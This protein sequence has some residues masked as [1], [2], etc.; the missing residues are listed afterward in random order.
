[1]KIITHPLM[2][3]MLLTQILIPQAIAQQPIQSPRGIALVIG[4]A[5][6]PTAQLHTPVSDAQEVAAALSE[7]GYQ[8]SFAKDLTNN[9]L[10]AQVTSFVLAANNL[11]LPLIFYYAG[12]G[13]QLNGTTY[14]V[15]IDATFSNASS[16]PN[17]SLSLDM[18]F[19]AIRDLDGVPKMFILDA[20]RNNPYGQTS[21]TEW[22]PG[23]AAPT[24]APRES[25]IAYATDPGNIAADG[26]GLHSPYTRSLIKHIRNPGL[27]V[28]DVFKSVRQ[29][30][31]DYTDGIQSPWEN[32]SLTHPVVIREPVQIIAKFVDVDDDAI[33]MANGVEALSWNLNG[34]S[35]KAIRLKSG[36][37]QLEVKIYNQRS[38]TGGI[39][40]WGH[41]PEGWHYTLLLS[42]SLGHQILKLQSGENE[43]PNN[44][45]RH[46]HLFTAASFKILVDVHSPALNITD[47]DTQQWNR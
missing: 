38:Y 4:N 47:V 37:N 1:M 24:R 15:P 17:E 5:N 28:E 21:P 8:V 22:V 29:E 40:P 43:P 45:S 18:L 35:D 32:T 13:A 3:L 16:I 20:C 33:L 14:L 6:Y 44:G 7:V 46:G 27:S 34:Q 36:E 12:H 25:L 11:K 10:R 31:I 42:D 9:E 41:K 39:P 2:A 23:L 26:I 19:D 30:V